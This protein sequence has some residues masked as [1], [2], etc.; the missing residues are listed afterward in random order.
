MSLRSKVVTILVGVLILIGIMHCVT[1]KFILF[2]S[3]LR[4]E[5]KEAQ[6]NLDRV[7]QAIEREIQHIDSICHDW[8][9]WD[10][11]IDFVKNRTAD[12]IKSNLPLSI[13]TSNNINL[14]HIADADG[15]DSLETC[16]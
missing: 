8:A 14:V 2:Q 15:K 1:A 13:F 6:R 10:E 16:A 7:V 9:T 5:E 12:Y 3:F 11:T 4:L